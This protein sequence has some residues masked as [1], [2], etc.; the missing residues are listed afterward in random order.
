MNFKVVFILLLI[1]IIFSCS[2]HREGASSINS[3]SKD[4]DSVNIS[5][6]KKVENSR[7]YTL[8]SEVSK[9]LRFD[10]LENGYDSFQIRI[11]KGYIVDSM[12]VGI[13]KI[14]K[15]ELFGEKLRIFIKKDKNYNFDPI[16]TKRVILDEKFI[17]SILNKIERLKLDQLEDDSFI[18]DYPDYIADGINVYFEFAKENTYRYYSYVEP[19]LAKDEIWQARNVCE[20]LELFEL[21]KFPEGKSSSLNKE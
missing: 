3:Y 2:E 4:F 7:D 12:D 11:W 18:S 15:G 17:D 8:K 9:K 13:I 10:Q 19:C 6:Y 14:T 21:V 16:I 20:I 5:G 1:V